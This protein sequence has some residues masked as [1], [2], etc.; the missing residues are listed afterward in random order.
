M[1]ATTE[2]HPVTPGEILPSRELLADMLLDMGL[3]QEALTEYEAALVRSANRF[4]SLYGAGRAAELAD[5]KEKAVWYYKKLV[6]ITS[7]DSKRER[8]QQAKA[9]LAGQ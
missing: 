8:L 3:Y 6:E 9:F 5:N 4:N 1:E 7:A 2:K